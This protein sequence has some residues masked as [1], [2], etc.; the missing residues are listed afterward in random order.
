M[1]AQGFPDA[2]HLSDDRGSVLEVYQCSRCGLV[3][4]DAEPVP[5]YREVVRA[6]AVSE[7]V[8]GQKREQFARF[9]GDFSLEGKRVVEVGCGRGEFL[10]LLSTMGVSAFGLEYGEAAVETCRERGLEA[11]RGYPGK[12]GGLWDGGPFDAFLMLMFLEHMPDPNTALAAIGDNLVDGAVG[13]VEVPSFDTVVSVGL[14][15]EFVG[16]HLM[17]FTEETLR[18]T[19]NRNGFEVIGASHL[20]DDYVLSVMVR[21]RRRMDLSGLRAQQDCVTQEIVDYVDRFGPKKVAVWGAGHQALALLA[22][23]GIADRIAYVVDSA[24]FK[25]G[26]FTPTTHVPVVPPAALL[27]EPVDAVLVMA[28]SYSDEVARILRE[29]YDPSLSVAVVRPLGVEVLDSPRTNRT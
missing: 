5:Y 28:A 8:L 4:L 23:T 15:S 22:M 3:Q 11:S 1:A 2:E 27:S 16:D 20:R 21:K 9:V 13:I 25:Q 24:P 7:V 12:G 18:T 10:T 17:Y 6:A 29:Q 14:F 26:R 19:L